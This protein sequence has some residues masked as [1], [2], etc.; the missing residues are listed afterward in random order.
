VGLHAAFDWGETFLFSV[1]DSGIIAPGHLLNASF[2]G[3]AWL[4]GGTVGPEASVMAFAVVGI[5]AVIFV[6]VF[7][8]SP[9]MTTPLPER[10]V[11]HP[12]LETPE[13]QKPPND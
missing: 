10:P 7:P 5:S 13:N 4:T 11:E 9:A 2:H 8:R 6:W 1:P 3:P 12:I